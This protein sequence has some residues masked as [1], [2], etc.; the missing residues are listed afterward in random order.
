MVYWPPPKSV[1]EVRSFIGLANYFRKFVQDYAK[2][3]SPLTNLLKGLSASDKKGKKLQCGQ[4]PPAQ[5]A[6]I[7]KD[8][9]YRWTPDCQ[10]AFFQ[11]K[12]GYCISTEIA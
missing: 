10:G 11:L 9:S 12:N 5:V 3:A 6:S 1:Y 2:I 4:L 7:E 8:F